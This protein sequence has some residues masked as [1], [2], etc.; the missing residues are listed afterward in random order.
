M[1]P[2]AH[3][4]RVDAR[5]VLLAAADEDFRAALAEALDDEGYDVVAVP[6]AAAAMA[7]L[8][9]AA[10]GRAPPPD[11]LVLDLLMPGMSGIDFLRPQRD[12][13]LILD[14]TVSPMCRTVSTG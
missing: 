13:N 8:E 5:A 10:K 12:S 6:N 9:A 14:R 11:L 4:G 3:A 2:S 1:A 7:A